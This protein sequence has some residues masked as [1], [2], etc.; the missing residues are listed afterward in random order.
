VD[1]L[2]T[3]WRLGLVVPKRHARRAVTRNL[4]RRLMREAFL[5]AVAGLPKGDWLLRL[6]APFVARE[7]P[8]AR[9]SALVLVTR[10][11]LRGLFAA[12]A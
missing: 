7:F 3:G 8:S 9:S 10:G 12:A 4:L 5:E 1:D 2:S 6:K 11:E